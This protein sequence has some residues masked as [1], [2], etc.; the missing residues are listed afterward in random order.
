MMQRYTKTPLVVGSSFVS[1]LMMAGCGQKKDASIVSRQRVEI[2]SRELP[3]E[4][5][6]EA[7][8]KSTAS[9]AAAIVSVFQ[10]A[11]VPRQLY[12]PAP[13][14]LTPRAL[15]E[16]FRPVFGNQPRWSPS[17]TGFFADNPSAFFLPAERVVLGERHVSGPSPGTSVEQP[18]NLLPLTHLKSEYLVVLR[19]FASDA[20]RALVSADKA[21][22][23]DLG[24]LV[25]TPPVQAEKVNNFLSRLLRRPS[26]Q[27]LLRGVAEYTEVTNLAL[28]EASQQ[29][30]SQKRNQLE[31]GAWHELCVALA[32]DPRV[33]IR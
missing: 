8:S 25:H 30:T 2:S 26:N 5:L 16:I 33:F 15:E 29:S 27:A 12:M 9:S 4:N 32:T 31:F 17:V 24:R 11:P 10:S 22:A 3:S 20:C 1:I 7:G 21:L 28:K 23:P 6:G 19:T 14:L 13:T 18:S